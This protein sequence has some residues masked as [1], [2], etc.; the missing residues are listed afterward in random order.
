MPAP[1][2]CRTE[3]AARLL[4]D[5]S[6]NIACLGASMAPPRSPCKRRTSEEGLRPPAVLQ[7][8]RAPRSLAS[9]CVNRA[10]NGAN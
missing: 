2:G 5:P 3:V 4:L 6:F 10:N 1:K 7:G 9:D 8:S